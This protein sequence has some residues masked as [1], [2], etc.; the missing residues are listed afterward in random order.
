V[1][2]EWDSKFNNTESELHGKK[3]AERISS[4]KKAKNLDKSPAKNLNE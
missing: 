4:S 1:Q 3:A 2:E